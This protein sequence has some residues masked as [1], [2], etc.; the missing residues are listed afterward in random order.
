ME[1]SLSRPFP[2][3]LVCDADNIT[4]KLLADDLGRQQRFQVS[5][6][7]ARAAQIRLSI[8]QQRPNILLLSL[9]ARDSLPESLSV[10]R[11]VREEFPWIRTI[12]LSEEMGRELALEV[13]R[14]GAKGVFDRADYDAAQL[15]RC[16]QCVADGQIWARSELLSFVLESFACTLPAQNARGVESLTPRER[17]VA[18]LVSN[19]LCNSDIAKELGISVH[20]VKNY[21]FS[22]F[23]KTGVSSRAELILYLLSNNVP[24]E[25]HAIA[26]CVGG[27]ERTGSKRVTRA[28]RVSRNNA[29]SPVRVV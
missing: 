19:G 15:C 5:E 22:V 28:R 7:I 11:Q 14:A 26:S 10:L 25:I 20:T 16:I 27:Y 17:D 1:S 3:V 2:Q 24:A 13:F 21:L 8:S 23:D 6:C 18:G 29:V 9:S 4:G 12:V